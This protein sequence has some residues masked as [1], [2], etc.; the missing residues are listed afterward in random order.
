MDLASFTQDKMDFVH[1]F[2]GDLLGSNAP[3]A[4]FHPKAVIKVD[5]FLVSM[6]SLRLGGNEKSASC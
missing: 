3:F 5:F 4:S 2:D 1:I 6:I